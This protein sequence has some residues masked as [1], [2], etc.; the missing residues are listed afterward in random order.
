MYIC[1]YIYIY[2]YINIYIY[3]Y[4]YI[5][6]YIYIHI[7]ISPLTGVIFLLFFFVNCESALFYDYTHFRVFFHTFPSV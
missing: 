2:I 4:I 7:Y 5:D 3:I 6:I 1:I